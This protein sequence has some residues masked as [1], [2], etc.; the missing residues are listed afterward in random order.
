VIPQPLTSNWSGE[1]DVATRDEQPEKKRKQRTSDKERG[2]EREDEG[3]PDQ[4]A[5]QQDDDESVPDDDETDKDP[6]EAVADPAGDP[7]S[8]TGPDEPADAPVRG[9]DD[10]SKDDSSKEKN[11]GKE[12]APATDAA[13][14]PAQPQG[15]P[16]TNPLVRPARPPGARPS[17]TGGNSV[18]YLSPGVYVREVPSL[19]QAIAGVGTSTAAFVGIYPTARLTTLERN[20]LYDETNERSRPF[21]E[22]TYATREEIEAADRALRD[23]EAAATA[24]GSDEAARRRRD[25]ARDVRDRLI[26]DIDLVPPGVPKLCTNFTEFKRYFGDFSTDEG[27]RRLAHAVYGFF[28]NQGTKCWVMRYDND[29]ALGEDWLEPFGAIDEIAMVAAPGLTAPPIQ[30]ALVDHCYLLG[31]R[32]AILDMPG[33]VDARQEAA[34]ALMDRL[35]LAQPTYAAIY[36]P[37]IKVFDPITKLQNPKGDGMLAQPPSGHLAGIYARVDNTRGVYKAPANEA[38]MGAE[39]VVHPIGRAVQDGLNPLGINCIRKLNNKILVWGART[40]GGNANGEFK[41][42]PVRRTMLFLR[43][44]IEEGTQWVV[45]EPNNKSLWEKIKRNI[46]AFLTVV[47]RDGALVGSTPSEAFYVKCDEETNPPEERELGR[48]TCEIGVAIVRPA[49][50]VI[51]KVTQWTGPNRTA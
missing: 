47:W 46:A 26:P 20:P 35:R 49:E 24:A 40:Y 13:G 43:E 28:R 23:A 27:Q 21:I 25:E 34:D 29:T 9:T 31:D 36:Y 3:T 44:S 22:R 8:A 42:I 19:I 11:A 41:Y 51:F 37:W 6:D 7:G 16:K 38:V 12:D 1:T 50:F 48:V 4:K 2:A 18:Q 39:D 33:E 17:S 30:N 45:F 15:E 10:P 14:K 32:F 5:A